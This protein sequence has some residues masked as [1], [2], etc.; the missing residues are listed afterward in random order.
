MNGTG[1]LLERLRGAGHPLHPP[2]TGEPWNRREVDDLAGPLAD[3]RPA[4]VLLPVVVRTSGAGL[5][6][7]RRNDSLRHH[8]GQI[9]FPGGRIEPDDDGP[10]GAAL[11]E[12]HEEIGLDPAL[13]EPLGFLDPLATITG[14][15]V[16]PVLGLVRGD[17]VLVPDPGEVAETFEVPLEFLLDPA[18]LEEHSREFRGRV[19]RYH[20]IRWRQ[21][22]IW[23]ATASIIANLGQRLRGDPT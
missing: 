21:Y 10:L 20:V 6:F 12:T 2:P 14:F 15:R 16:V 23:G 19:R 9:S 8:A 22:E 11:R 5:I 13:T 4:A 18:H 1:P 3:L 7:T 17:P